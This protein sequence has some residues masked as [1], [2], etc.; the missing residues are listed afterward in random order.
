MEI[1]KL[2][3]GSIIGIGVLAT[4][5]VYGNEASTYATMLETESYIISPKLHGIIP[6]DYNRYFWNPS[7]ISF[8]YD[9]MENNIDIYEDD[10]PE[11]EVVE[12]PVFK[13][14][15]FQFEKPVWLEPT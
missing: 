7:S 10:Y 1:D 3:L 14:M 6:E 15:I 5:L 13:E 9:Y 2:G 11:I 12:I 8:Q 4:T